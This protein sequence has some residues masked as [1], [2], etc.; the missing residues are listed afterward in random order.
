[1]N[2][3]NPALKNSTC[4]G[5]APAPVGG[6]PAPV[7]GRPT[8]VGGQAVLEGVMMRSVGRVS[9]AVRLPS[10]EITVNGWS[11]VS[12]TRRLG[13]LGWPVIRGCV[14]FLEM[15]VIGV[16]TLNWSADVAMRA[17]DSSKAK[18]SSS[19][20]SWALALSTMVALIAG[21][22]LFFFTPLAVSQWLGVA[23]D[24]T[25]FNL[26]AG[27]V[28]VTLFVGYMWALSL[29]KEFQ[30]VFEYHGAEHK[31]IAAFEADAPLT[32]DS[33]A[34][35]TR[36]HP[37]C[38]TSFILIVAVLAI[39]VFAISDTLYATITGDAPSLLKRFALHVSLLPVVSGVAYEAL[40]LSTR[41]VT[42]PVT[43]ALIQPGLWLQRITTREP[44]PAQLEVAIAALQ[45]ALARGDRP[46]QA[47]S[48]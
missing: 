37:R 19:G 31:T 27:A 26:V 15:T 13:V 48:A 41:T 20:N 2:N 11:Y 14:T 45:D 21:V 40:R 23:K 5:G 34:T 33:C 24:A 42:H 39:F 25:A 22:G 12:F 38:G 4:I 43:R 18:P 46:S 10:G 6:T 17:D 1:M 7:G 8:P 32:P 3:L 44:N 29:S 9:T 30:R 47:V 16:R 35:F 28:R 36:F